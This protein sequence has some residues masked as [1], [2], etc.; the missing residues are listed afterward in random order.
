MG[1]MGD[2][3]G[4]RPAMVVT[5]SVMAAGSL[6]SGLAPWGSDTA[7]WALL[8]ASRFLIGIGAGGVYPLSHFYVFFTCLSLPFR[9]LL[10]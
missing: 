2:A 1:Y 3:V 7:V 5:L 9:F 6:L 10:V 4:R 8:C